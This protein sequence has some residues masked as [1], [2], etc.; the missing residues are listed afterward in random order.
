MPDGDVTVYYRLIPTQDSVR[1]A[2]EKIVG[3]LNSSMGKTTE[4]LGKAFETSG[5]GKGFTKTLSGLQKD[6]AKIPGVKAMGEGM[7]AGGGAGAGAGG[8]MAGIAGSL[9]ALVGIGLVISA[10]LMIVSAFFEAVGPIIKVM[11]KVLTAMMLILL[12]PFLRILLPY[13]PSVIKALIGMSQ[14][15][16]G[17]FTIMINVVGKWLQAIWNSL[18]KVGEKVGGAF[19]A[20]GRGDIGGFFENILGAGVELLTGAMISMAGPILFGLAVAIIE[21]LPQIIEA[22]SIVFAGAAEVFKGLINALG[23]SIFGEERWANIKSTIAYIRDEV[24]AKEGLW[25]KI[26]AAVSFIGASVFGKETW[27]KIKDAITY[28]QE[29]IFSIDGLWANIKGVVDYIGE[30]VFGT[31]LWTRMKQAIEDIKTMLEDKWGKIKTALEDIYDALSPIVF[32]LQG[33]LSWIS[34][35][36]PPRS[37]TTTPPA[38]DFISRPGM[39]IQPFSPEDTVIGVKEPG[40]LGGVVVQNTFH[41]DARVDKAE[42]RQLFT[43]FAREQARELRKRTSYPGGF[44]A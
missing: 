3:Q 35:W 33:I 9:T 27:T 4:K 10:A 1:K 24:F 36:S 13:L 5:F 29:N 31:D 43:K 14:W 40:A 28:L 44:Y 26:Q 34:S 7:A 15:L 8:A 30:S 12:M 17:I 32:G 20:L 22:I 18:L 6:F 41:I 25:N 39:A 38:T 19:E 37:D 16:A 2:A 42:L 21:N 11:S 23:T